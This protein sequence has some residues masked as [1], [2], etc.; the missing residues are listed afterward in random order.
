MERGTA[1]YDEDADAVLGER[2]GSQ[3]IWRGEVFLAVGFHQH[4]V[5]IQ[6]AGHVAIDANDGL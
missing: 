5:E 6:R 4:G 2:M 1:K 3:E